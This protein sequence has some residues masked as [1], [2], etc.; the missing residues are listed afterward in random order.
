M[1]VPTAAG[2]SYSRSQ[3]LPAT[4]S[5]SVSTP[6]PVV[7]APTPKR[8]QL[9]PDY[10]V[11]SSSRSATSFV[12]PLP[13]KPSTPLVPDHQIASTSRSS[14]PSAAPVPGNPSSLSINLTLPP[15]FDPLVLSNPTI[16]SAFQ[17]DLRR[18]LETKK[19]KLESLV[20]SGPSNPLAAVPGPSRHQHHQD[21]M[22]RITQDK[23]R[24]EQ[25]KERTDQAK[26]PKNKSVKMETEV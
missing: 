9:V 2:P 22:A 10:Q 14:I 26:E 21:P 19:L 17:N 4:T 12:P 24:T 3:P 6:P 20:N 11:A 13:S 1:H 15:D 23:E 25:H 8:P 7:P 16:L 18:R 5:P